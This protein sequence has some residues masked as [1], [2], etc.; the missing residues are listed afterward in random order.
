IRGSGWFYSMFLEGL[1]TRE[2]LDELIPDRPVSLQAFDGHA[3]WANSLALEK[4]GV[5]AESED[6][7]EGTIV[8][9]AVGEPTGVFLETAQ[10]L[11]EDAAPDFT[12]DE[13][14]DILANALQYMLRRG[15]TAV[16]DMV[17]RD[18]DQRVRLY[19]RLYDE[20]RLPVRLRLL[21]VVEG[22]V[23]SQHFDRIVA[24]RDRLSNHPRLSI[25]GIK[26]F[27]DGVI[28]S[29][30][31]Y[32]LEP[33]ATDESRGV[34]RLAPERLLEIMEVAAQRKLAVA[35]HSVGDAA[36]RMALDQ[37][38][39]MGPNR[40]PLVRLEHLELVA[41]EDHPRLA[42]LGVQASMQPLHADPGGPNPEVGA[43]AENLGAER[44]PLTFPIK[45][46]ERA[47]VALRFGSDW[48]VVDCDPLPGI[49]VAL[50][51]QSAGGEPKGGWFPDERIS[52]ASALRAYGAVPNLEPGA[53]ANL[54]VIAP[55]V[56]F[57]DP[58]TLWVST[59]TNTSP[60]RAVVAHG[61]VY[62]FSRSQ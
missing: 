15:V 55:G 38:E 8:R 39:A 11:L 30:T 26:L 59:V 9:D 2:M 57:S 49:A 48:P 54:A 56:A 58:R 24:L 25:P 4:A 27:L 45:S 53:P 18:I 23:T 5:D 44:L 12:E 34:P 22:D 40:P 16:D 14:A 29:K 46:L 36:T 6:P 10:R 60:I 20:D 17:F 1:P 3:R 50:T 21:P 35:M 32:L 37:L 33:Y 41:P 51:R 42:A 61:E 7:P 19:E 62:D 13:Q 47:G 31:A 52:L 43:W 28:E